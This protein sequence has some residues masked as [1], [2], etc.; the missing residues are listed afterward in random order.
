MFLSPFDSL[1]WVTPSDFFVW[2]YLKGKVNINN[3]RDLDELQEN[4]IQEIRNLIS[5]ILIKVME[6][7]LQ[8]IALVPEQ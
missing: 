1:T 7:V 5:D 2:E 8:R 3:Y 4:I 6:P